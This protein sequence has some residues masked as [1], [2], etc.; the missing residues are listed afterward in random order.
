MSTDCRVCNSQTNSFARATILNRYD[1]EYF[2]CTDCQFIQTETPYWLDEAYSSAIVSTDVGLVQRNEKF[3]RIVDRTLKFVFP[4]AQQCVDFGGGYGMFTRMMRDRGHTFSHYDPYCDNLFAQGFQ[5]NAD[6][7]RFDVLTAFEVFEHMADPQTDLQQLDTMA[8][9]WVVSTMI[10]PEPAPQPNDW[11]YY[12]LDGGQHVAL[13]S[14]RALQ[15]A[16]SQHKRHLVTTGKGL[17]VFS[18]DKLNEFWTRQILRDRSAKLLDRFRRR[19]SLLQDDFQTAVA[20]TKKHA[21]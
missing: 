20:A 18:R 8:E 7:R 2:R 17:H 5:V 21:A 1:I 14:K 12:V 10:V 16:A 15:A 19:R 13:W 9:Q 11:W 4:D 3:A 6:E